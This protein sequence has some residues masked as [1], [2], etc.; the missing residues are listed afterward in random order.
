M[1]GNAIIENPIIRLQQEYG[2]EQK[3]DLLPLEQLQYFIDHCTTA[4][5]IL[6]EFESK[7]N[8][9]ANQNL[10][11]IGS[12][13]NYT[14]MEA[15]VGNT[16]KIKRATSTHS[17]RVAAVN[18]LL[19]LL[20]TS[21]AQDI[22]KYVCTPQFQALSGQ[23]KWSFNYFRVHLKHIVDEFKINY[24]TFLK[25]TSD[26]M[27]LTV[28][29]NEDVKLKISYTHL[30]NLFMFYNPKLVADVIVN[31]YQ[32]NDFQF[33]FTDD[34]I[35]DYQSL[36][37]V[38]NNDAN[39]IDYLNQFRSK[40]KLTQ[41]LPNDVRMPGKSTLEDEGLSIFE[42]FQYDENTIFGIE[43]NLIENFKSL[44][45]NNIAEKTT[46]FEKNQNA[47]YHFYFLS[48]SPYMLQ[49]PDAKPDSYTPR[50]T[51][52]TKHLRE[53][54]NSA[55]TAKPIIFCGIINIENT[56]Y[57]PYFI[58][59][60]TNN[61]I[62]V[63]T[64]D[65]SPQIYPD[66]TL[67]GNYIDGKLK[68][69]NKL[70]KIFQ[71]IF[72][73]CEFYDPNVAQMMR[74][75]DC[76]PSSATTLYD[77]FNTCLTPN[78]LLFIENG[79]LKLDTNSLSIAFH[80]AAIN[81]YSQTFLYSAELNEK[82]MANRKWWQEKLTNV[83]NVS[84]FSIRNLPIEQEN[85][86]MSIYDEYDVDSQ[87]VT[88]FDY[89]SLV[90]GQ[91][92]QD[93]RGVNISQVQS[94]LNSEI[95]G[96]ELIY[97]F[98]NEYKKSLII[99]DSIALINYIKSK[100]N[101]KQALNDLTVA[102]NYDVKKLADDVIIMILD[103]FIPLG[104]ENVFK[105]EV[106]TNLPD[107]ENIDIEKLIDQYLANKKE[108]Y[109]KL[110]IYQQ[111]QLRDR[112]QIVAAEPVK[113]KLI[114]AHLDIVH[115]LLP[116]NL[117]LYL[118]HIKDKILISEIVKI[119]QA[120]KDQ[121]PD[122]MQL[123][124]SLEYLQVYAS[125]QLHDI[126]QEER[127]KIVDAV[128][129]DVI[130]YILA[131]YSIA[132]GSIAD[133]PTYFTA[134]NQFIAWNHERF[135][136]EIEKLRKNTPFPL[137]EG[138][139]S[140][141]LGKRIL[142]E[143]NVALYQDIKSRISGLIVAQI[144]SLLNIVE[145]N[146]L[147]YLTIEQLHKTLNDYSTATGLFSN[148]MLGYL[149]A[150]HSNLF[151]NTQMK[152]LS[153]Y[154]INELRDKMKLH[155]ENKIH[156]YYLAI[157]LDIL[158]ANKNKLTVEGFE[159]LSNDASTDN[160]TK[161]LTNEHLTKYVETN[162]IPTTINEKNKPNYDGF[163]FENWF[164]QSITN[165]LL[166]NY[167]QA[168]NFIH[169]T[170]QVCE[171]I[172]EMITYI[173][174]KLNGNTNKIIENTLAQVNN[175]KQQLNSLLLIDI[176]GLNNNQTLVQH[177]PS[178]YEVLYKLISSLSFHVYKHYVTQGD[179]T[180]G[181]QSVYFRSLFCR[182]LAIE[183]KY[184]L[185]PESALR[186]DQF[187]YTKIIDLP[188]SKP[189]QI[190]DQ[191]YLANLERVDNLADTYGQPL[192]PRLILHCIAYWYS[193]FSI[194]YTLSHPETWL[195]DESQ[196]RLI[197]KLIELVNRMPSLDS[198][199]DTKTINIINYLVQN[200]HQA[201]LQVYGSND[202]LDKIR[203][204]LLRTST[205]NQQIATPLRFA[206]IK[207]FLSLQ[208]AEYKAKKT[209]VPTIKQ[210]IQL[211]ESEI[212]QKI[213]TR[214]FELQRAKQPINF[215][216]IRKTIIADHGA[217]NTNSE[218]KIFKFSDDIS[219]VKPSELKRGLFESFAIFG[220]GL[221]AIEKL[222]LQIQDKHDNKVDF[223][224][225]KTDIRLLC[226][227]L[228]KRWSKYVS[229]MGAE[230]AANCYCENPS[231]KDR[232][233]IAM[234]EILAYYY[235]KNNHFMLSHELLMP[236]YT[237]FKAAVNLKEQYYPE[238]ITKAIGLDREDCP[239]SGITLSNLITTASGY[240]IDIDWVIRDYT[241]ERKLINPYTQ[242]GYSEQELKDIFHHKKS[243]QLVK[244]VIAN[245]VTTCTPRTIR[246]LKEYLDESIFDRGFNDYYDKGEN[247]LARDA[248]TNF[249]KKLSL[250]PTFEQEALMNEI[251][252]GEKDTVR[253]MLAASEVRKGKK[254]KNPQ[255]GMCLTLR[256]VY[257]ARVVLAYE[258]DTQFKNENLNN[259]ARE[260]T[261]PKRNYK[262]DKKIENTPQED[263]LIKL[264]E[265]GSQLSK[266]TR[267][268]RK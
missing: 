132:H 198:Q 120:F 25:K 176:P 230:K 212:Q 18:L 138:V 109:N 214:I 242:T 151:F 90:K 216:D 182:L 115:H 237:R 241:K 206:E 160:I 226:Q 96:K 141:Y 188:F 133:L 47:P 210:P 205:L 181:S 252:P 62:Q 76:G 161:L 104:L 75:R 92:H 2:F 72:P 158:I 266:L 155:V 114:R 199:F 125:N 150:N 166:E 130:H 102:H 36:L 218:N 177:L 34:D 127:T 30:T 258:P 93:V 215:I 175:L 251:I 12:G 119:A 37:K 243:D 39:Y 239:V 11:R 187:I 247:I 60:N 19:D 256:G 262:G 260:K 58:Y 4:K 14:N 257:L 66:I 139:I 238:A 173:E 234:A 98:I 128:K 184:I 233:Y 228:K 29:L 255:D 110:T 56:H 13:N 149:I 178:L 64:V 113:E 179:I 197:S 89:I 140:G 249:W 27:L 7:L 70:K 123:A 154:F 9:Y 71:H 82:S 86:P 267:S 26:S 116:Q 91:E 78:P 265:G 148:E 95:E 190:P 235:R 117:F 107:S 55:N 208:E 8:E 232:V 213:T 225:D 219:N 21:S 24:E 87:M 204:A 77:A 6:D 169:N 51:L 118:S 32:D 41:V 165:T 121:S 81:H 174:N 142:R 126:I 63:I 186:L 16:D 53:L 196:P 192:T 164:Q 22:Y 144:E 222:L 10:N 207:E 84:G 1:H 253:D 69:G 194:L 97:F 46:T 153:Q 33:K 44:F 146:N 20:K 105:N 57:L 268:Y 185:T 112:L 106:L 79:S 136:V 83:K 227:A 42:L 124:S 201:D 259:R 254:V 54:V 168:L 203:A 35:L 147:G 137:S 145:I 31:V 3:I 167:N 220:G 245:N 131:N 200:Y 108:I 129:K 231:R 209:Q 143:V 17:N 88:E 65:P 156:N 229:E 202:Y 38:L 43:Q 134:D 159:K 224:L 101:S 73:E 74:E 48:A 193:Q 15:H 49:D 170:T 171:I 221:T 183:T 61:Q 195:D 80:P 248:L 157:S 67:D 45:A 85:N 244:Q 94:L 103:E 211:T 246:I 162:L 122:H 261:I 217:I 191:A 172:N 99:P 111:R 263:F 236:D 152:L 50:F 189:Y 135:I 240:A 163:Y 40:H 250:I 59:K 52:F 5:K 23:D 223:T 68:T 28:L 100:F 180:P 264:I